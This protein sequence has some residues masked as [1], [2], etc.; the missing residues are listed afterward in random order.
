[1]KAI[2][3][4]RAV[5][6]VFGGLGILAAAAASFASDAETS[7]SAGPGRN[8][9]GAASATA[10][11]EGDYGFARTNSRTGQIN[12]AR[13]V[14]VGVDEDGISLSFS[15]AI[16]PRFG[17]AIATNFSMSIDADGR[18]STSTGRAEADRSATVS[19]GGGAN[20][21]GRAYANASAVSQ[22][23]VRR[24]VCQPFTV[25]PSYDRPGAYGSKVVYREVRPIQTAY[26][27]AT[28]RVPGRPTV[29]REFDLRR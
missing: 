4:M 20:T 8:G 29:I 18:V 24:E 12:V 5:R 27:P 3:T 6:M 16:A 11:Y 13:G 14:A 9:A 25:S 7:A 22:P 17:P 26:A 1:M 15:N 2:K 19:V 10:H 21:A 28:Y 23:V